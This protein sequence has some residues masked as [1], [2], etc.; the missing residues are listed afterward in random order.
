MNQDQILSG[1][2]EPRNDRRAAREAIDDL[3]LFFRRAASLFDAPDVLRATVR[4][5]VDVIVADSVAQQLRERNLDVLRPLIGGSVRLGVLATAGYRT[6]ADILQTDPRH[7]VSVPGVGPH[8]VNEVLDA[9]LAYEA[10]LRSTTFLRID[11][12]RRPPAHIQLLAQLAAIRHTDAVVAALRDPIASLSGVVEPYITRAGPAAQGKLRQL[13]TG[14]ET[15]GVAAAAVVKLRTVLADPQTELLRRMLDSAEHGADPSAYDSDQLWQDYLIDAAAVNSLL[16]TLGGAGE[17][18]DVEASHGYLEPSL[19]EQI[20]AFPLDTSLLKS[21]LRRYQLFGAQYAIHQERTILGD[22]MGLGKTIQALAVCA[23]LASNGRTQFLVVCPASVQ[24][25]WLK[26][27]EKHTQLTA[28]SLHGVDR[29]TH[30]ARWVEHGGIAVTTFTTVGRLRVLAEAGAGIAMLIVDEAHYIKNPDAQRSRHVQ[31]LTDQTQHLL[32]MTGTPM[33]NRVEEFRNLVRYLDGWLATRINPSDALGGA[34][35]FRRAVAPVYLRRN[36]E[37]VLTELPEKIEIDE[38]VQLT[39]DDKRMYRNAA[40]DRNMMR[41]RRAAYESGNSAKLERLAEIV[42]E[43]FE[44]GRKV[45]VFSFFLDVLAAIRNRLGANAVGPLTGSVGPS[46]RQLMVDDFTNHGEPVALLSQIEAGG[47]GLNIQ[48]AS[49]VIITEPQWKPSSE[50]Q[51]IAR[52][53]RMGQT[54]TVQVHRLLAKDSVD[55]RIVEILERKQALFDEFARKSDTKSTNP[56]AVDGAFD[57]SAN[58]HETSASRDA[59]IIDAECE[60][61]GLP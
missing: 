9:A 17:T 46:E 19:R 55:E 7:L 24:I 10:T 45:I 42:D 8:T 40:T 20:S 50:D 54:R 41:M 3:R 27:I 38:W 43:A 16:S 31:R 35:Q 49:V 30:G 44:D 14:R 18:E 32:L 21:T 61:L 2:S 56:L 57:D 37:D 29:E 47:V 1:R 51:A 6:V 11:S 5:Q 25:N 4:H 34:R 48:A 52:A 26:E 39:S 22:E 36:Q 23:H 60:R 12:E 59:R 33:E 53:H 15:K 28:F 13:F 58:P